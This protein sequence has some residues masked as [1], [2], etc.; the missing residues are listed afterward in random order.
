MEKLFLVVN[1]YEE[2]AIKKGG[3]K[4]RYTGVEVFGNGF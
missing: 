3:K 1:E 2:K 4:Y